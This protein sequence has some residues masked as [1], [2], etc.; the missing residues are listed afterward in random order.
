[1]FCCY[2]SSNGE[3]GD[4]T[5]IVA[6]PSFSIS[7]ETDVDQTAAQDAA[8]EAGKV[9]Q[10]DEIEGKQE[11]DEEVTAQTAMVQEMAGNEDTSGRQKPT[12]DTAAK[13]AAAKEAA[14]S[15]VPDER[16]AG[17][18]GVPPNFGLLLTF[19]EASSLRTYNVIFKTKPLCMLFNQNAQPVRVTKVFGS[20]KRLGVSEGS[21]LISVGGTDVESLDFGKMLEVL[22]EKIAPLTPDGLEVSFRD[23]SGQHRPILFPTQP[24]GIDFDQGKRPIKIKHSLGAAQCLGVEPDWELTSVS[25]TNVEHMEFDKMLKLLQVQVGALPTTD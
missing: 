12:S 2:S 16:T 4:S 9:R 18:V 11:A 17:D 22:T 20:A 6:E 5:L 7:A 19:R 24:L 14:K 3:S 13:A 25:G 10:D 15:F 23:Q 1:M 8:G 21:E